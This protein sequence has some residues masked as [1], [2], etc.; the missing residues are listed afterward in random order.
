MNRII[1]HD[2][3]AHYEH[4]SLPLA[5]GLESLTVAPLQDFMCSATTCVNPGGLATKTP[6]NS[7]NGI[8]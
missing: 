6:G 3:G 2:A 4:A 8:A 5:Q 1:E 7:G